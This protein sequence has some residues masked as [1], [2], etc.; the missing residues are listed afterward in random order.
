[1]SFFKKIFGK[2]EE[3]NYVEIYAPFDGDIIP[4]SEI[5]DEAFSSK[6]IGDGVGL[7]PK[8]SGTIVAPCDAVDFSIFETN[9]ATSFELANELELIVHFGID[10]VQLEGKGFTR[11]VNEGDSI[12]K[13]KELVKFDLDYIKSNAKSHK[14]PVIITSMDMVKKIET[15]TGSV[16]SGDLLMKVYLKKL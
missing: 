8:T 6:I 13:G 11:L 10:T 3:K 14:T 5:P 12:T 15:S 16:K 2:K 1:M 4:L 7:I 9:H